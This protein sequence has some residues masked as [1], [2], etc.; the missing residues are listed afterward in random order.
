MGIPAA[1]K[2]TPSPS[3]RRAS[4]KIGDRHAPAHLPRRAA[5]T[6]ARS[7]AGRGLRP[8]CRKSAKLVTSEGLATSHLTI[9]PRLPAPHGGNAGMAAD[10]RGSPITG[11]SAR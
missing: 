11:A 6:T 4:G 9:S 7:Q 3:S 10:V 8:A 5:A 2:A 1:S